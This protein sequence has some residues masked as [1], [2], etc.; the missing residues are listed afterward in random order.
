[1]ADLIHKKNFRLTAKERRSLRRKWNIEAAEQ[2]R[3][4]REA[5]RT[6]L[7]AQVTEPIATVPGP[8]VDIRAARK[9]LRE[10]SRRWLEDLSKETDAARLS[11][12]W[13]NWL[14]MCASFN[15]YSLSNSLWIAEQFPKANRVGSRQTWRSYNRTVKPGE[16]PI[17]VI[18]AVS[19]WGGRVY[20]ISQT[21]GDPLP[22]LSTSVE[23]ETP[24]WDRLLNGAAH[25]GITVTPKTEIEA[26]YQGRS[27]G[28]RVEVDMTLPTVQRS[29]VLIHE[30]AHELLHQAELERRRK[31]AG[32]GDDEM[33]LVH[34]FLNYVE[35][36]RREM[37]AESVTYVI[38][39]ALGFPTK[40]PIYVA[41]WEDRNWCGDRVEDLQKQM[42]RIRQAAQK[43]LRAA[44]R[45]RPP[46][47]KPVVT[48]NPKPEEYA[49]CA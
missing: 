8:D 39:K 40:A 27:L 13:V 2:R 49:C 37:E 1:M 42:N 19:Y 3:L 29:L 38:A 18:C 43:I 44:E 10:K 30:L 35:K 45:K 15:C 36:G 5:K 34:H 23:G 46:K 28:G 9:A 11:D 25:L 22:E 41:Y 7:L 32:M 47:P 21:E 24:W 20:D 31:I 12:E 14:G 17:W 48:D 16:K 4:E 33:K 6:T 26:D